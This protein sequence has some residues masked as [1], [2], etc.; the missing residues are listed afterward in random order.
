MG[1]PGQVW[2]CPC[3]TGGETE[4]PEVS[5]LPQ[6]TQVVSGG[7]WPTDQGFRLPV[8]HFIGCPG[9]RQGADVPATVLCVVW[10]LLVHA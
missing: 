6:V 8:L 3:G 1:W 9:L 5:G 2:F 7:T 4:A 10:Q